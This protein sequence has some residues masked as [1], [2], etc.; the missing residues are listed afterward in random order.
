[1][2]SEIRY[3]KNSPKNLTVADNKINLSKSRHYQ[4][5]SHYSNVTQALLCL[6]V[7]LTVYSTAC[8]YKNEQLREHQSQSIT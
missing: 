4:F 2:S 7:N 3:F 1:M 6:L 8:S 5:F